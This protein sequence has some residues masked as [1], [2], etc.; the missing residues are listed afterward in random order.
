MKS[1]RAIIFQVIIIGGLNGCYLQ[2]SQTSAPVIFPVS[3]PISQ[4][5]IKDGRGRFYSEFLRQ[6]SR[7]DCSKSA[8]EAWIEPAPLPKLLPTSS[9]DS[10]LSVKASST[11]VFIIPGIFWDCVGMA[12]IPYADPSH[13]GYGKGHIYGYLSD[14]GFN[15]I[16]PIMVSGRASSEVNSEL[17]AEKIKHEAQK[18]YIKHI[19]IL[20][21]S[22]GVPDTLT[23]LAALDPETRKKIKS[24]V[25]LSGVGLGTP[26]AGKLNN[27]YKALEGSASICPNSRGEEVKS[28][29]YEDRLRWWETAI[30]DSTIKY[31]SVV[32][33]S[34]LLTTAPV[35]IPFKAALDPLNPAN[36]GQVLASDAILPSS[37]LLAIVKSDHWSYTLP[38]QKSNSIFDKIISVKADFPREAF[39]RSVLGIVLEDIEY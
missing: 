8:A 7:C 16:E 4:S 39:I 21:Y 24:F 26:I 17:I 29:T 10:H 37:T 36:D 31:Y 35:L 32:S 2:N 33:V 11:A 30:Y 28:L 25:S 34:S 22:K 6:L 27:L 3:Q 38:L 19:I 13:E 18:K 5:N 15:R 23:A 1:M 9:S 14:L 12:A 20:G